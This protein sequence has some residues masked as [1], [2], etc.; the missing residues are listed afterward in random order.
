MK[1]YIAKDATISEGVTLGSNV[2]IGKAAM[3]WPNVTIGDNVHIG[4]YCT[5]GE[6]SIAYYDDPQAH[7]FKTTK[8]GAGSVIRSHTVIYE[9]VHIGEGFKT[10]HHVT[11]R[12]ETRIGIHCSVGTFTD[13]QGMTDIGNYVRLHSNVHIG[14]LTKI[15]DYAWIYPF[16]VTTND[17]YPPLGNLVGTHV[18]AYAVVAT[19]SI[20]MPGLSIGENALVAAGAVVTKDVAAEAVAI[21]VPAKE[22]GTV[23]NIKDAEGNDLYPWKEHFKQYRGYPWQAEPPND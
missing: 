4:A 6:P 15:G 12:E 2:T 22:R 10:G 14:Q 18:G 23:R 7:V 11:I 20:V 9:D 13:I 8:I 16:V 3:I 19:G 21:G 1:T 5:I 17:P